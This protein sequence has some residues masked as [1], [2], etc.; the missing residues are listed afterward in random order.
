MFVRRDRIDE[1]RYGRFGP[2]GQYGPRA[3]KLPTVV[4]CSR[5]RRI[6]L[7]VPLSYAVV[8][9]VLFFMTAR[10]HVLVIQTNVARVRYAG[11]GTRCVLHTSFDN[12]TVLRVETVS[13]QTNVRGVALRRMRI[14]RPSV[15]TGELRVARR[16]TRSVVVYRRRIYI[17]VS[18]GSNRKQT[19][20]HETV[21]TESAVGVFVFLGRTRT[22]FCRR[23]GRD[24]FGRLFVVIFSVSKTRVCRTR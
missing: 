14:V 6:D 9:F 7:A 22:F 21:V 23:I 12:I 10:S 2:R 17:V 16:V 15:N 13:R 8:R 5:S 24:N 1:R 3:A 19:E 18:A 4:T 20:K 11:R